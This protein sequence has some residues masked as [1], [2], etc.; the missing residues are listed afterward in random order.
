MES[1]A[2]RVSKIVE[3]AI[4]AESYTLVDL[5]FTRE[6]GQWILRLFIDKAEGGITIEDCE[7]VS[8]LVSPMLDVEDAIKERYFLEVSSPGINRRIRKKADFERFAGTKVKI[9][10]RSH[11]GG[12]KKVTGVIEGVDNDEVVIRSEKPGLQNVRRVPL[13]AIGRANLQIL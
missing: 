8:H 5:E 6:G 3:P 1:T 4:E 9:F 12:H 7:R 13:A 11:T 2:D 10:L